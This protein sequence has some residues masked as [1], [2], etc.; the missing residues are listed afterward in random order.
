M[1]QCV[2]PDAIHDPKQ[3]IH[4]PTF[5]VAR[6]IL[7]S[8]QPPSSVRSKVCTLSNCHNCLVGANSLEKATRRG[9]ILCANIDVVDLISEPG[10][11]WS[12][13]EADY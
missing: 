5:P 7:I 13:V 11:T 8:L 2:G 1:R 9:T 10:R 12:V 4:Q 6:A 3:R